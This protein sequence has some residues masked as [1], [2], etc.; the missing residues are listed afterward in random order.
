MNQPTT[1]DNTP[2]FFLV[3]KEY[4]LGTP[5]GISASGNLAGCVVDMPFYDFAKN[6]DLQN[7]LHLL[8]GTLI[9]SIARNPRRKNLV[10]NE[11]ELVRYVA[12][13]LSDFCNDSE[14][15]EKRK[16]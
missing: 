9:P 5:K 10:S 12:L 7:K 3:S 14:E 4:V 8:T 11:Q 13:Y 6:Y 2:Y 15:S 1:N 16:E